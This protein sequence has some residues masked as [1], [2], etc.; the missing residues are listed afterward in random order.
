MFLTGKQ[1][2]DGV[3]QMIGHI[4]NSSSSSSSSSG[5][6]KTSSALQ[7]HPNLK[8]PSRDLLG[9]AIDAHPANPQANCT[10][11]CPHPE[12]EE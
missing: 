8:A 11:R 9:S 1:A 6:S 10:S 3:W 12:P 7:N 2:P 4:L 5:S